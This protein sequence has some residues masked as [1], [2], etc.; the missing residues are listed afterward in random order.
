MPIAQKG[1]QE[2]SIECIT[3]ANR[4][5]NINNRWRCALQEP[6]AGK[7]CRFTRALSQHEDTFTLLLMGY[8]RGALSI[9]GEFK[10]REVLITGLDKVGVGHQRADTLEIGL[11]I[12]A[13]AESDVEYLG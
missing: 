12:E 8:A 2:S 5:L 9:R 7:Q 3:G 11:G 10:C 6:V 4:V 1:G 13:R